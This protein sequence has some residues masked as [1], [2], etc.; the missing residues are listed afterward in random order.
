MGCGV[1]FR[2]AAIVLLMLA[3]PAMAI[4]P[5][6]WVQTTEADF[7]PGVRE[8][9]VVTN[10]GDVKLAQSTSPLA[11]DLH[12]QVGV[13]FDLAATADGTL[14]IAGG[15]QAKLLKRSGDEIETIVEL[16]GEQIFCLDLTADG[17][18]LV[19]ISGTQSRLAI[20]DGGTLTDL[21]RF[22]K[23]R[24]IW[25]VVVD[26]DRIVVATGTDGRLLEVKLGGDEPEIVELFDAA[27]ANILCLGRDKQGRIYAGTDTDG[28]VYRISFDDKGDASVFVLFDAPEPE[29]GALVVRD[30]GTVFAGTADAEQARPGRLE[31][32]ESEQRGRPA[33]GDEATPPQPRQ[34][35]EQPN[36]PPKAEP[37]GDAQA[38]SATAEAQTPF[39]PPAPAAPTVEQFDR[40]RQEVRRRLL[41][42]RRLQP[43]QSG[44]SPRRS[45]SGAASSGSRRAGPA[46]E[47]EAKSGN[48]VYRIT[49][50]GFVNEVFRES[51]MIL[52]ILEHNGRL[53]VA[54][55]NEGE[56]FSVD[57]DADETTLLADLSSAAIPAVLRGPDGR[58]IM[59]TANP[60]N[61]VRLD[62]GYAAQGTY[63]GKVL[64]ASQI[65]QWGSLAITADVPEGTKLAVRTRSGNVADPE[66]APWTDWSEPAVVE[67]DPARRALAPQ[68]LQIASSPARYLQYRLTLTGSQDAS[69]V[70][71]KVEITYVVPN[72]RP[73]IT[74]IKTSYPDVD[75]PAA[76]RGEDEPDAP[77]TKL[78]VEWEAADSN[79]DSLLYDLDY[80]LAG[81]DLWLPLTHD[82]DSTRYEWQT[83]VVPDGR[84]I[85]RVTASDRPDNPADMARTATRN[86]DPILIDNTAP[87]IVA[88]KPQVEDGNKIRLVLTVTDALSL[89]RSVHF[90][91][92]GDKMWQVA[93]PNDLVFDST[94][95]TVT[96]MIAGLAPGRHL[97]SLRAIDGRG[98][99]AYEALLVTV[100]QGQAPQE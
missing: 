87:R 14:Y 35:G 52:N 76:R 8:N 65:S 50:D 82:I 45:S 11:G 98:N 92:D 25:D 20:L 68:Y 10:L 42:A 86:S 19:G 34:P 3:V 23:V 94:S 63:T 5:A 54:T 38:T 49:A 84:Y 95:E 60:A 15:P 75:K 58:L 74:A 39:P 13:I 36:L 89:V 29:I 71:D 78:K 85:L 51:V 18:L 16:E 100:H 1:W 56:L 62:S 2:G 31:E 77:D 79:G 80:Q 67:H 53:L 91:V 4:Q 97:I 27:Q 28:L 30:D 12:E 32:A 37:V 43:L 69:P 73:T 22:E 40:L 96:I 90:A 9:T 64:D 17:K 57:V 99:A 7:E 81:S 59:G 44:S 70:V 83:R 46:A 88:Q 33:N 21:V 55:G 93:L 47:Q 61:L 41:S 6:Q 24:Y 72:L 66:K 26:G 48:A